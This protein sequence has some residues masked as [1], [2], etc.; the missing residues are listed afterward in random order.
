M[1]EQRRS[2]AME[3][4]RFKNFKPDFNYSASSDFPCKDHPFSSSIGI[5][6]FCL[7]DRLMNLI[8][9]Y[10]GEH[11]RLCSC[12]FS[13][14]PSPDVG[15]VGRISFLIENETEKNPSQLNLGSLE[16]QRRSVEEKKVSGFGKIGRFFIR[17][18]VAIDELM[19]RSR[20]LCSFRGGSFRDHEDSSDF[21]FSSDVNGGSMIESAR[22]SCFSSETEPRKSGFENGTTTRMRQSEFID[23]SDDSGF[24]DLKLDVSSKAEYGSCIENR[25]DGDGGMMKEKKKKKK[26]KKVWKWMVKY[27][28]K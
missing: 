25:D 4:E 9:S 16:L 17:K 23:I 22:V 11:Q 28:S 7:K 5:C 18:K 19:S 2:K 20:S 8:C 12:T 3:E 24:I 6:S 26:G 27:H 10:C 13:D 14:P 21:T 15:S 1:K